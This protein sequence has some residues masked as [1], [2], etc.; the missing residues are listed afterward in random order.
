MG[1]HDLGRVRAVID[2]LPEAVFVMDDDGGLRLT[3]PAAD[4]LFAGQPIDDQADLLSRFEAIG[5]ERHRRRPGDDPGVTG[6][7]ASHRPVAPSAQPL[8]RPSNDR[9]DLVLARV[10]DRAAGRHRR[11]ADGLRPP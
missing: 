2:A 6:Q 5:P 11:R 3:N 9:P 10:R 1:G 4:Q 7:R 8:V